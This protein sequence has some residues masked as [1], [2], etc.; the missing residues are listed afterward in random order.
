MKKY[1]YIIIGGKPYRIEIDEELDKALKD[2]LK[3]DYV[4]I[5]N[6]LKTEDD[7]ISK[8]YNLKTKVINTLLDTIS[9]YNLDSNL[10]EKINSYK[11][12]LN[13]G[14]IYS[15][16]FLDD[17]LGEVTNIY[18]R[19]RNSLDKKDEF[20]Q[21]VEETFDSLA[22]NLMHYGIDEKNLNYY[23]T[24]LLLDLVNNAKDRGNNLEKVFG[25][26]FKDKRKDSVI[27]RFLSKI[28][29][30]NQENDNL[31]VLLEAALVEGAVKRNIISADNLK[32]VDV[33]RAHK[34]L[35]TI[36]TFNGDFDINVKREVSLNEVITGNLNS[37]VTTDI[38]SKSNI[39]NEVTANINSKTNLNYS[40]NT[41]DNSKTNV[42]YNINSGDRTN[43]VIEPKNANVNS[44]VDS[45]ESKFDSSYSNRQV[46][47]GE[48]QNNGVI[49][50][51]EN[52]VSSNVGALSSQSNVTG[53]VPLNNEVERQE[54]VSLREFNRVRGVNKIG[55]QAFSGGV[56]KGH[57]N[58]IYNKQILDGE[59]AEEVSS[60]EE[61]LN[62]SHG[63]SLDGDGD[64]SNDLNE[65]K[66]D[67]KD[68]GDALNNPGVIPNEVDSE[69]N[70]IPDSKDS[71]KDNLKDKA[72]KK[73]IATI[74]KQH[75]ELLLII[76]VLV[77]FILIL[78]VVLMGSDD[79]TDSLGY[80]EATC[81]INELTVNV[82]NCYSAS[83]DKE[84]LDTVSL[85]DYI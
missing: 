84:V 26:Y 20:N 62:S 66:T 46:Y 28:L 56:L 70:N 12:Y 48:K 14:K 17:M 72:L 18:G 47:V 76:G 51:Q 3:E 63:E 39:N 30:G 82:T 34:V 49:L 79:N 29:K 19:V 52:E 8:T 13:N 43:S 9:T 2:N 36:N 67:E 77:I 7:D 37:E 31:R 23:I 35:N 83:S 16:D 73:A 60:D 33:N 15:N 55:G 45:E 80:D 42:N 38:S 44:K 58:G 4:F 40:A 61:L 25:D 68:S 75:P 53:N 6:A 78:M 65:G 71:S 41:V 59:N 50:G 22:N 24:K 27:G 32:F 74:L 5:D 21:N 10:E 1:I 69:D 81:N 11:T 54:G 85:E 64:L 57:K